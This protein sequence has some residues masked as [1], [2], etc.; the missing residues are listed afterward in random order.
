[1]SLEL[2]Q[3]NYWAVLVAAVVVFMLG[4]V[5]YTALF[6]DLWLQMHGISEEHAK[7]LREKQKSPATF[8]G[9]MFLCYLVLAA[10]TAVVFQWAGVSGLGSGIC[11][12]IV[13]WV[14]PTAALKMTDH[15]ASGKPFG[16]FAIDAGFQLIALAITG[17]VVGG[18]R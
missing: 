5:W 10:V 17:A 14:A 9:G 4:G 15:I 3:I 7:V 13:L 11:W 2:G 1:M 18:W 8:F 6:G 12:G 16:A